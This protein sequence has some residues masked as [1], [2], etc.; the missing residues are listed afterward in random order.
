MDLCSLQTSLSP[1][2]ALSDF[3]TS[4]LDYLVPSLERNTSVLDLMF[5]N[6]WVELNTQLSDVQISCHESLSLDHTT[7]LLDIYLIT[8]IALAPPST[9]IGYRMDKKHKALWMRE[10]ARLMPYTPLWQAHIS[11]TSTCV[12]F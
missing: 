3:V 11:C 6:K 2:P 7:L 12:T 8:S 10:F 5:A 9:P 1:V 4:T